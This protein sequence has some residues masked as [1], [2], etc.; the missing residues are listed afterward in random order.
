MRVAP[1]RKDVAIRYVRV[2]KRELSEVKKIILNHL[3]SGKWISS[4][5][6]L[7]ATN[8]KYFDRRIRELRDELGYDI[9]TGFQN[10]EPHYRLRSKK[11]LKKKV[12]TYLG[13]AQRKELLKSLPSSCAICGCKFDSKK[14]PV[15]DHRVPLIR[16]GTGGAENYQLLCHECN[17]QKRS[18][19]RGCELE[20]GKCYLAYPEKYPPAVMLRILD[21]KSFATLE[22]AAKKA[23][24]SI[25]TFC[26]SLIEANV[27]K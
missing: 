13:A 7:K 2:A 25:E 1:S 26:L 5:K 8:Q 22:Q 19:C 10:G 20:C 3:S 15:F 18:Q 4:S 24:L 11:R 27:K 21:R 9:E 6:L 23:G 17:N 12:R 16:G 14:K